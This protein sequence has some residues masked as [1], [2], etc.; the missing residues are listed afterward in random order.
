MGFLDIDS[1]EATP[2]NRDPFDFLVL[3][4]F[5]RPE[6]RPAIAEAYPARPEG[7]GFSASCSR[8]GRMVGWTP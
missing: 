8:S 1:L 3:Q 4:R 5:V 2:L 7:H 6:T